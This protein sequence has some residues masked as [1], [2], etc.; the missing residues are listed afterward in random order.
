MASLS[1]MSTSINGKALL[2]GRIAWSDAAM[3]MTRV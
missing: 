3:T 2:H 1:Q